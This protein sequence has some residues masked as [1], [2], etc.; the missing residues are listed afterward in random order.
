MRKEADLARTEARRAAMARQDEELGTALRNL[1]Y[2]GQDL[3]R[4]LALCAD[5]ADAPPEARLRHAL[6]R[7]A[8]RARREP[9]AG[10]GAAA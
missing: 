5:R 4:A 2:R 10:D 9:A 7:M 8:P 3:R 6:G 1:G